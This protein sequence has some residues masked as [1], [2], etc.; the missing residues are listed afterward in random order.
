MGCRMEMSRQPTGYS[1][2][3]VRRVPLSSHSLCFS[4]RPSNVNA[5]SRHRPTKTLTY[6][7]MMSGS[8]SYVQCYNDPLTTAS[9]IIG[10]LTFAVAVIASLATFLA[11][12]YDASKDIRGLW[13]DVRATNMVQIPKILDPSLV[14]RG[15]KDQVY[16]VMLHELTATFSE[17]KRALAEALERLRESSYLQARLAW[18]TKRGNYLEQLEGLR[19]LRMEILTVQMGIL[20]RYAPVKST[21]SPS[22]R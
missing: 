5:I 12:T 13:E 20:T 10:I 14:E 3:E 7:Y 22:S 1:T 21:V 11:L 16:L 15:D 2:C 9:N 4:V 8:I 18:I 6:D 19:S 17:K